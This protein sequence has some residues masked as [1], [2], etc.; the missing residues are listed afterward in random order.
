MPRG[1]RPIPA[2][3]MIG[4]PPATSNKEIAM[5][6]AIHRR[7]ALKRTAA[8]L[9]GLNAIRTDRMLATKTREWSRHFANKETL[10]IRYEK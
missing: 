4:V 6:N 2:T 3:R 5:R 8:A 9:A 10:L 1:Q 7:D